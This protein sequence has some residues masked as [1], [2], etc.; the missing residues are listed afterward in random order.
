VVLVKLR[1]PVLSLQQKAH[2][3]L[4]GSFHLLN[5]EGESRW[6][7]LSLFPVQGFPFGVQR[8]YH[9]SHVLTNPVVPQCPPLLPAESLLFGQILIKWRPRAE[10]ESSSVPDYL[11]SSQ[12]TGREGEL[13]H[14][15]ALR[16][17]G[18]KFASLPVPIP[19]IESR[20]KH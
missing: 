5:P 19:G 2:K 9:I 14:G 1:A 3:P 6:F 7:C 4:P 15:V 13:K 8:L 10:V 20:E 11:V 17:K 12:L 16:N 18:R